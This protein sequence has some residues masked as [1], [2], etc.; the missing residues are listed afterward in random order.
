MT[1][2]KRELIDNL[3][4]IYGYRYTSDQ[5]IALGSAEFKPEIERLIDFDLEQTE[6]G[7]TIFWYKFIDVRNGREFSGDEIWKQ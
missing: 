5:D 7:A 2:N 1:K 3:I 4:L 6:C